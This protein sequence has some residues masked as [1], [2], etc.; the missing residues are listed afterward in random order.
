MNTKTHPMLVKKVFDKMGGG[1]VIHHDPTIT[2]QL[3]QS[4]IH[5]L[6]DDIMDI[7]I[8]SSGIDGL[9]DGNAQHKVFKDLVKFFGEGELLDI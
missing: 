2:N 7:F 8:K 1:G 3:G 6:V 5:T 9:I 4:G